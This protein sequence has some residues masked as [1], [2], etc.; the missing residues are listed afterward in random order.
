MPFKHDENKLSNYDAAKKNGMIFPELE[1]YFDKRRKC[2]TF[3][4]L[5]TRRKRCV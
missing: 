4:F 1:K 5:I 2:T 3:R